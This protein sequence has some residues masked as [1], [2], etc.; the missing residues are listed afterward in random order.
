MFNNKLKS[1]IGIIGGAGVGLASLVL[2]KRVIDKKRNEKYT[3]ATD[4]LGNEYSID[5]DS[6]IPDFEGSNY[7][8]IKVTSYADGETE[9]LNS[10]VGR[11]LLNDENKPI[12]YTTE[13]KDNSLIGKTI[14]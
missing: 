10:L 3:K 1:G 8:L 2:A 14:E 4:C 7:V 5:V 13:V 12:A 6:I 11:V 9:D